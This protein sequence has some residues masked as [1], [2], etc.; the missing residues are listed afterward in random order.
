[1]EKVLT[2]KNVRV[3]SI[4]R[5]KELTLMVTKVYETVSYFIH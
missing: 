5:R 1:M 3:V 2:V 4:I